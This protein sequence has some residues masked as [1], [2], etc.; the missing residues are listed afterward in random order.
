MRSTYS[1]YQYTIIKWSN[2]KEN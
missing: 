1:K 2:Q